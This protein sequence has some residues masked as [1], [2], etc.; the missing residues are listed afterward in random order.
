MPSINFCENCSIEF[1]VKHDAD[2]EFFTV[3]YC[4]FC[5]SELDNDEQYHFDE[6]EEE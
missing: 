5:S 3:S 6:G 4:P 2:P 1:K